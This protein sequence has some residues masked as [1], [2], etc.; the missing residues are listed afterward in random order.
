MSMSLFL[1]STGRKNTYLSW[2][3]CRPPRNKALNRHQT[4]C[5][6]DNILTSA[7]KILSLILLSHYKHGKTKHCATNPVRPSIVSSIG[8]TWILLPYLTSGHAW[9]LWQ[10]KENE[11][12]GE[13]KGDRCHIIM[14]ATFLDHNNSGRWWR[15]QGQQKSNRFILVKQQL[16]TCITLFNIKFTKTLSLPWVTIFHK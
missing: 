6:G 8:N 10:K 12:Y 5:C 16:C 1:Y 4:N 7:M 13:E 9:T 3:V 15:Q 11:Y 14:V 2:L